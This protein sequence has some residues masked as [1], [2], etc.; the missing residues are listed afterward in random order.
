MHTYMRCTLP[1]HCEFTLIC[2]EFYTTPHA[3]ELHEKTLSQTSTKIIVNGYAK[4]YMYAYIR[5][6]S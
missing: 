3:C 2:L 6:N 1:A 4:T 5:Y